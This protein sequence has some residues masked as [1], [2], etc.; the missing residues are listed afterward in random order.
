MSKNNGSVT[1]KEYPL[2]E[3]ITI[4]SRTDLHGNIVEANEDFIEASGFEWKDIV[5]QPH[6]ILRHPD[7]P[8]AVFKDFWSTLQ[9]GK[10]WSQIVKNRR[11]NGDH[12]WVMANAT[13][14]FEAGEITGYMSVRVPASRAEIATAEK[15]YKKI[16][17][18]KLA[19]ECG[20][21]VSLSSKLNPFTRFESSHLIIF[22]GL[23]LLLSVNAQLL[24]TQIPVFV[25]ELFDI[26]LI[27]LII[28]TSIVTNRKLHK[29]YKHLTCIAEG[30]FNQPI[31]SSGHNLTSRMLGRLKSM[32]IRLGADFDDA[33]TSLN[34]A[35][36]I[37]QALDSA[38]SN[39]MVVDRFRNIIFMNKAVK[40][41]LKKVEPELKKDLPNFDADNLMQE[42]IDV[43]HQ[44]PEHQEKLLDNLT[45]TYDARIKVGNATIDLIVD[46]IFSQDQKRLGTV[47]E[48]KNVTEQLAIEENIKKIV[49]N[50]S[51][52][53]LDDRIETKDLE[54]F[55]QSLSNSINELLDSFSHLI[56]NISEIL[57]KMS[58]GDL[59]NRMEGHYQGEV[60]AMKVAT[61]SALTNIEATFGQIKAGSNEIGGMA[62]EVS[63]A[64]EDLSERTQSQAASLEQT[65]SSM[66][67]ITSTVK[68]AAEHT[69]RANQLSTEA[70]KEAEEAI[71]EMKET[72]AAIHGISDLSKQ[73]ADITSVIDGI[74]FQ[75]NLLALNAAVEAARAGE[76]GKGFAVVAGEV[77]N[78]A[79]KSADSSKEISNLITTATEQISRGTTLVEKTNVAF[80]DVVHKIHEVSTLVDQLSTGASEQTKG[81]E[82]VNIAVSSLDEMTQQNA[83]LVEQLAATAGNMSEQAEMQA[84]FVGKFTISSTAQPSLTRGDQQASFE[85]EEAKNSHRA[86]T[87]RLERFLLGQTVDFDKNSARRDDACPLGKWLYGEGQKYAPLS[88]MQ[89]LIKIHAE[90]HQ[91]VGKVIDAKDVEDLE[92]ANQ[93]KDKV[94]QYSQQILELIDRLKESL[95]KETP[96]TIS[97]QTSDRPFS[98]QVKNSHDSTDDWNDF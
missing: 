9:A 57:C 91:T 58:N 20:Y 66:E 71:E 69:H 81:L 88:E 42:S 28:A 41:M 25:L 44:H 82:Q 65:A 26:I 24:T 22:F 35:M 70:T 76:H 85:L 61:N 55:N 23:L 63:H 10:P 51:E 27:L 11:K 60:N 49:S 34:K 97:K 12:Y 53:L 79:Q 95:S 96:S 86:W 64:S 54:G 38:S 84:D 17:D 46:P 32:Q 8:A 29:A 94:T 21:P 2:K 16:A 62:G 59:T 5:G 6:N 43:F 15:A 90:M 92:L 39:I 87:V 67:Q 50:A 30:N 74:A 75:T 78:L 98:K 56:H 18:G 33:K 89:Q 72:S 1:Q 68:Q 80:S 13:P 52:G 14:I 40:K 4:V 19:L 45:E 73:I 36:R 31:N 3:G 93:E 47:A 37:E 7:V 83:A 77:R 48:W